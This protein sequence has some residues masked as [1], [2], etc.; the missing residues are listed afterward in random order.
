VGSGTVD[1]SKKTS[2]VGFLYRL[3]ISMHELFTFGKFR[4]GWQADV[5]KMGFAVRVLVANYFI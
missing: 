4:M 5:Y 1:I 3:E 2:G